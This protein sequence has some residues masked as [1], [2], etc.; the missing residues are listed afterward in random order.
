LLAGS[1]VSVVV[2]VVVGGGVGGREFLCRQAKRRAKGRSAADRGQAY[3]RR[4]PLDAIGAD[5]LL[6][7]VLVL[8]VVILDLKMVTLVVIA[9]RRQRLE[10]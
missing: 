10:V 9:R 6:V 4:G 2:V 7:L 1:A 8:R 3:K 5:L